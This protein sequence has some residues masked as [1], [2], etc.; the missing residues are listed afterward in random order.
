M[1]T[2][3]TALLPLL[4]FVSGL[5]HSLPARSWDSSV[6][7][8]FLSEHSIVS[9]EAAELI[10]SNGLTIVTLWDIVEAYDVEVMRDLGLPTSGIPMYRLKADLA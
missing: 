4:L 8:Q 7:A 10:K 3:L 5:E 9:I 1:L 2:R 6:S